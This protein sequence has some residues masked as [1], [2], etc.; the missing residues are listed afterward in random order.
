MLLI[1]VI[2]TALGALV[3][4]SLYADHAPLPPAAI[5]PSPTSVPPSEQPGSPKVEG[6]V[7]ATAHPLYS[8]LHGLL[9]RFFDAINTKD[10]AAWAATVTEQRQEDQPEK[11][12]QDAYKTTRDG[13]I[14][15]Y[16]I[17]TGEDDTARA[18]LRFTSIQDPA[19]APPELHA[20]CIQWN[21]VWFFAKENGEWKLASGATS[22]LPQHET[23]PN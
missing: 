11:A 16:R 13:S 5:E 12:W 3:A 2:A 8:T 21:V 20:P 1:T 22:A 19:N 7:D 9:Q 4:R 10:Y 6:T 23:C 18:L 14:V 15:V 17:E